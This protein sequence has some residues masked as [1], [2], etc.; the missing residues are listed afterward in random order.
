MTDISVIIPALNEE[1]NIAATLKAVRAQ[2][3]CLDFDIVVSD[4]GSKDRTREISERLADKVVTTKKRGIWIGRNTGAR[5]ARGKVYVFIDADTIIPKNYLGSVFPILEDTSISGLSCA[6]A[7]SKRSTELK[8]VEEICNEYL[9]L[10]GSFGKGELLGFNAVMSKRYFNKAGGFPNAPLEDGAL[11]IKL[12]KL[13]R[14]V[15]MPEPRVI[16]SARR[17]EKQGIIKSTIYYA[18]IGI[19]SALP[20]TPLERLLLY[21]DYVPIR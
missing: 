14:L 5:A 20:K 8:L 3:T 18:Q 9:L 4:G 7:F 21:K 2:E 10:K 19:K 15:Y 1:R 17:I 13:G 6:F 11:A 16:T 12:R